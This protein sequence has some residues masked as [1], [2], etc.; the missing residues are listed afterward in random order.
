M[1]IDRIRASVRTILVRE[2]G[3][4][5]DALSALCKPVC[6]ATHLGRATA[7]QYGVLRG[8]CDILQGQAAIAKFEDEDAW[9]EAIA[10][11]RRVRHFSGSDLY[12]LDLLARPRAVA[13]A[14]QRLEARGYHILLTARG[15]GV[16][17]TVLA[18]ICADIEERV[19]NLGGRRVID[20]IF[21][22]FEVNRRT[23][24]GSLL[25]GRR[26]GRPR[27]VREPS[28]PWHFLYNIAWKHY[29]VTPI[30]TNPARDIDELAGLARDMA[31][32]FDV[33]VYDQFDGMSIGPANFHQAFSDR[34]VYDELFAFQQW[35]P[36]MGARVL[37][38]WLDHLAATGCVLPLASPQE[39]SAIG[40]SL[41]AG[42]QLTALTITYPSEHAGGAITPSKADILFDALAVP[43]EELN[44]GYATPLDTAKRNS[45]YFPLYKI[46]DELCA[47]PPRGMASRAIFERIYTLLRNACNSKREEKELERQMGAALERM[48]I[49]A[50]SL[51]GNAPAYAGLKYRTPNQRK[52]EA[53]FE[54]DVADVTPKHLSLLECKKKAL[55]NNARAGNVLSAAVDLAQAFLMPLVQMLR[56]EGELRGSGITFLN[57]QALQLDGRDIQHIA[58][59]MTD[60][61]SMQDRM[62]LRA[63]LT[64]LSLTGARLTALDPKDQADADKVNAQLKSVADG[65]ASLAGQTSDNFAKFVN[66]YTLSTWWLSIDQL[67]FLCERASDLQEAVSPLGSTIFGTGDLMNEIARYDLLKRGA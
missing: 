50:V 64:G 5:V 57:G 37:S 45:P 47:L 53:P 67:Y 56:H 22:W 17:G 52:K 51:T 3:L 41:V 14:V 24:E 39:W 10:A 42:S 55:T 65:I 4:S 2:D 40:K 44:R 32:S 63:I 9:N 59:T 60:H 46:A 20:A 15:V 7:E 35:Q 30:S 1:E 38:S 23:Y 48:T 25:Y 28:I 16:D 54:L 66:R 13:A 43:I 19:R 36:R 8:I 33:E 11:S 29:G 26:I 12:P 62:F 31:A 61:G 34:I 58:I 27:H 18:A 21:K 6:I 49:E